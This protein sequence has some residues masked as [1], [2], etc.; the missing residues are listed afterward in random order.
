MFNMVNG[1]EVKMVPKGT[2][3]VVKGGRKEDRVWFKV[4][5]IPKIAATVII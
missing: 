5:M 1:F 4:K 3:M 2:P